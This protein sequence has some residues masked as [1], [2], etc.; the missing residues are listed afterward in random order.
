MV[1]VVVMVEV[2]FVFGEAT[3]PLV[4]DG[5]GGNGWTPRHWVLSRVN[6][7]HHAHDHHHRLRHHQQQVV[8]WQVLAL[9]EMLFV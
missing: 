1:K 2:I 8:V 9:H 5:E 3:G 7:A 4:V 6:T